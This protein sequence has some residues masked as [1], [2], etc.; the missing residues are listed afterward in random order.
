M[1]VSSRLIRS[2]AVSGFVSGLASPLLTLMLT[3]V[4]IAQVSDAASNS[5]N[6]LGNSTFAQT[7]PLPGNP[8]DV[9]TG[10]PNEDLL[11][12]PQPEPTPEQPDETPILNE[13]TPSP[14][15]QPLPPSGSDTTVFIRTIDVTGSTVYTPEELAAIVGE[16]EGQDLTLQQLQA[17]ADAVTQLY[18]NDGYI[19]SRAVLGNQEIVDGVLVIQVVEGVLS[20]IQIEGTYRL[21][22]DYIRNRIRLGARPPLRTDRLEDQLRLLRIDPNIA[23]LEANLRAGENLGESILVVRVTEA[24][25]VGGYIGFDNYVPESVGGI[26][27]RASINYQNLTGQGD[28]LFGTW[29]RTIEGGSHVYRTGYVAPIN[30]KNGTILFQA[31]V[32]RNRITQEPFDVFDITGT[33]ERYELNYRQPI[34][35]NPRQEFALSLGLAYQHGQTFLDGEGTAFGFGPEADGVTDTTTISFGQDYVRRDPQGAWAFQSQF[36]FGVDLFSPTL[37]SG[38]IPD[39]RYF[40]WL[41]QAQRVQRVGDRQLLVIQADLQLTPDSLLS[42]QQFVIGGGQSIRGYRQNARSGD[43]GFRFS[44]ENRITALR[45]QSG[46]SVV[47]VSPFFDSGVVW[48]SGNNPNTLPDQ[49]FIAGLGFGVLWQPISKLD[50]RMDYGFP[51]V[52]IPDESEDVLQQNGIYFSVNYRYP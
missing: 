15:R 42:S 18:L 9:R 22:Q 17:A 26:R 32:D 46:R 10:D 11:F 29:D 27:S 19:T 49:T 23:S 30:A 25:N 33:T 24:N 12:E 20:D 48:N 35:R 28:R 14:D 41:G 13:S 4:A 2:L 45:D 52:D 40:S 7:P 39:G 44:V 47:Q 31:T 21:G 3:D 8:A 36:A 16:F 38:D 37:N 1:R 50:V 43:N 34:V 51:L 5:G 6:T